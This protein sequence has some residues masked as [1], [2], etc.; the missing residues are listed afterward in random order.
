MMNGGEYDRVM[1]LESLHIEYPNHDPKLGVSCKGLS[2]EH[3]ILMYFLSYVLLPRRNNHGTMW[4]E[5]ILILWAMV[6]EKVINW[7]YYM[8]HHMLYLKG[9][10]QTEGLGYALVQIYVPI[11]EGDHW[12]LVMVSLEF[13]RIYHLDAHYSEDQIV[14]RE[15]VIKTLVL[16]KITLSSF[17]KEDG[18]E[19]EKKSLRF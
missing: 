18:I 13:D 12:Y 1:G 10:N 7:P 16:Q 15:H 3:S 17:Y 2:N 11:R 6:T 4:N 8:V 14:K 19:R 5:D 9:C